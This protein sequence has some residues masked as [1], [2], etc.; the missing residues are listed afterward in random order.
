VVVQQGQKLLV[1]HGA[2]QP[3]PEPPT[4]LPPATSM[5][6]VADT[7]S[8]SFPTALVPIQSTATPVDADVASAPVNSSSSKLLVGILIIAAFVGGGVAVWLIR[9]P[10]S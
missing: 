3:A 7:P 6:M 8:I 5:P 1:K 9:D 4:P 2:T 10:N